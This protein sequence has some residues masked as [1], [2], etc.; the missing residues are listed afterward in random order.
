[1][2]Y[3]AMQL[4]QYTVQNTEYNWAYGVIRFVANIILLNAHSTAQCNWLD[5]KS[6]N[7]M[8]A[9]Q[10]QVAANHLPFLS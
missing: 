10:Y 5:A 7:I 4:T 6:Y 1:M 8:Q 3:D 9:K 2:R